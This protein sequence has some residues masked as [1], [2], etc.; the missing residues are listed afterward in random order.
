MLAVWGSPGTD[1]GQFRSLNAVALDR[2]GNI[3]AA[4]SLNDRIQKLAPDGSPLAQW[5]TLGS[6]PGEFDEPYGVAV[7]QNG[8][9]YV[10]DLR[11][12]RVQK[13]APDGTPLPL[14]GARGNAPT[15][16][17]S[18]P[19]SVVVDGQGN[20]YVLES[21]LTSRLRKFT[22]DGQVVFEVGG[23]HNPERLALDADGTIYVSDTLADQ[24]VKIS[25]SGLVVQRWGAFGS[26]PGQFYRPTGIALDG[27]GTLYVADRDNYRIQRFTTTGQ[28]LGQI[29]GAPPTPLGQFLRPNGVSVD[30]AGHV[31]VED[32][33]N[34]R[35]QE[36]DP[37]GL[38]V[39]AGPLDS[40]ELAAFDQR[41]QTV[42]DP[43]GGQ[44]LLDTNASRLLQLDA[45][46]SLVAEWGGWG[47]APGQFEF[48]GALAVGP[49]GAIYVADTW[50]NRVQVLN[51]GSAPPPAAPD[52]P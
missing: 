5:G 20:L 14:W 11:N 4:D 8:M 21:V 50:N 18:Y 19:T 10:A 16:S 34:R 40:G 48:P 1:P 39:R 6:G 7:D 25:A 36:L 43:S 41:N 52:E 9:I 28:P 2:D 47:S 30:A 13:L 45:Q 49:D 42:T 29:G 15:G 31:Y 51:L 27:R 38:P 35:M 37:D 46:G 32:W 17:F 33:G 26:R 44:W 24:V 3:Y 22:P 12:G 23:L